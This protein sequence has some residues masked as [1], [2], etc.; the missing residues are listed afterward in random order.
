MA[1]WPYPIAPRGLATS[2]TETD[3]PPSYALKFRNRFINQI[4]SAEKRQG[5]QKYGSTIAGNVTITGVHELISKL[6]ASTRFV[7]GD[8]NIYR[9]SDSTWSSV[10]SGFSSIAI[11]QSVQMNEKLIFYNGVDR[12]VY[13]DDGT[14]FSALDAVI[15]RGEATTGTNQARVLDADVQSWLGTRIAINDLVWN[16]TRNGYAII[17]AIATATVEHSIIGSAGTGLG[18]TLVNQVVGDRYEMIDLVA[19]NIIPT[20]G[21]NDNVATGT[22]GTDATT[23]AVSGVNFTNTEARRGDLIHNTTRSAIVKVSAVAT[24]LTVTSVAGQTSGDSFTFFKSAMPIPTKAHVHYN[25]LYLVDARDQGKIRISAPND[26]EGMTSDAGTLDAISLSFGAQQPQGEIVRTIESFQRFL[27]VGGSRNVALFEGTNPIASTAAATTDFKPVGLFPQGTV[28][29]LGMVSIGND[30]TFVTPDGLQTISL[31]NDA[32]ALNRANI[33]EPLRN[34]L[35][36]ELANTD[37]DQIQVVHYPRRSWVL[38]KV[39]ANVYVYSYSPVAGQ[40]VGTRGGKLGPGGSWSLF[41]GLFGQARSFKVM[42]DGTLVAG[43]AAGKVYRFDQG[44]FSDDGEPISTEYQ[45]PF[46]SPGESFNNRTPKI[47]AGKYIKP[48]FN[49]GYQA[50]Y[51]IRAESAYEAE[52]T[53]N[54]TVTATGALNRPVGVAV[55]GTDTIGGV[56]VSNVKYPLR[57]RG[58]VVR[59][60]IENNNTSGPDVLS[61]F[62]LYG[63]MEGHR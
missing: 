57:W 58:E 24:A 46:L 50:A 9:L 17:T 28:S 27:V 63:N 1:T 36:T 20:S 6:G 54:V 12:P 19:L 37:T 7:S 53:E 51:T 44:T 45:T 3:V 41:D 52:A 14:T 5:L 40:D 13:T 4:G 29:G 38:L 26:P 31:T 32:S 43:A 30:V 49:V 21:E 48:I 33:S 59:I 47:R 8:G 16:R 2:F 42:Q 34:T 23:I 11:I 39:G 55:I 25:R 60:T 18:Q 35:R 61:R 62:T 56:G 15:E 22:S 10:Y